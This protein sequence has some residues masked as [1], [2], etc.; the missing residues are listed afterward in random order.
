MDINKDAIKNCILDKLNYHFGVQAI[1]ATPDQ[2]Y[3]ACV[4]I[5]NE[6]LITRQRK[7]M[8][9]IRKT[10][11]KTVSYLCM[12]FLLGRSLKSSLYNLG[13]LDP[14]DAAINEL[15]YTLEE[16]FDMEP[17]AGLGNGGLGRLAA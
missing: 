11:A 16:I 12:E 6:I 15:G 1:D 7:F 14:F 4:M 13:L 17:N 10:E 3:R 8:T 9:D 2:Y 5:I